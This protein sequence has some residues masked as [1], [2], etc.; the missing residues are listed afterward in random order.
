M[1]GKRLFI[2]Y[3]FVRAACEQVTIC[4]G[5]CILLPP[6]DPPIDP[7]PLQLML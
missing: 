6:V 2:E 1:P 3:T 7:P 4:L 5:H